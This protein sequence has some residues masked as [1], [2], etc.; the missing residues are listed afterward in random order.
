MKMKTDVRHNSKPHKLKID[1]TLQ[2]TH[3]HI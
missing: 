1:Y 3:I 2:S